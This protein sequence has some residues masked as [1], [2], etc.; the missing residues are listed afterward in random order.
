VG[1]ELL[2]QSQHKQH[3]QLIFNNVDYIIKEL[4]PGVQQAFLLIKIQQYQVT[5]WEGTVH[6]PMA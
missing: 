4:I 5:Q 2:S 3:G 6:L 1:A